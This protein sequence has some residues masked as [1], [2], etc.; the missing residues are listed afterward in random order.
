MTH[1]SL[2]K[3]R[4]NKSLNYKLPLDSAADSNL[5]VLI[6]IEEEQKNKSRLDVGIELRKKLVIL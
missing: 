3:R 5:L 4:L 1:F 6:S 2:Q